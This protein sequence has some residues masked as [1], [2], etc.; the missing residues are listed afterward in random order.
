LIGSA[1]FSSVVLA[2][3]TPRAALSPRCVD[4]GAGWCRTLRPKWGL[5][6]GRTLSLR[7]SSRS[8]P[9][10]RSQ[11]TGSACSTCSTP[12][13]RDLRLADQLL[14][15]AHPTVLPHTVTTVEAGILNALIAGALQVV[16]PHGDAWP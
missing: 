9:I 8:S 11:T 6:R 1:G 14:T 10:P 4:G 3:T 13:M 16:A 7:T 12:P 5:K 15:V 2:I